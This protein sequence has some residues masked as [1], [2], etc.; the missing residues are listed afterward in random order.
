MSITI[1]VYFFFDDSIF[2]SCLIASGAL[3]AISVVDN[4][5]GSRCSPFCRG[6]SS[7]VLG[8]NETLPKPLA[9]AIIS[10]SLSLLTLFWCCC[11]TIVG[12][13]SILV[14]VEV[15]DDASSLRL[16]TDACATAVGLVVAT[17]DA[18][19]SDS[20]RDWGSADDDDNDERA[21]VVVIVVAAAIGPPLILLHPSPSL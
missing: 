14:A 9:S 18:E 19:S 7:T 1:L 2:A 8:F 3:A 21:W 4:G 17:L 13:L 6:G 11:V 12:V 15:V 16:F 10:S 20:R 5:G